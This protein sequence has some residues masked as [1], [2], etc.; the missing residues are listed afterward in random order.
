MKMDVIEMSLAEYFS[1]TPE[2]ILNVNQGNSIKVFWVRVPNAGFCL[3]LLVPPNGYSWGMQFNHPKS[4]NDWMEEKIND[5]AVALEYRRIF[6][7]L[8][9]DPAYVPETI[10]GCSLFGENH[11][12]EVGTNVPDLPRAWFRSIFLPD[13][14]NALENFLLRL[15]IH[16]DQLGIFFLLPQPKMDDVALVNWSESVNHNLET[17]FG[18]DHSPTIVVPADLFSGRKNALDNAINTIPSA[19]AEI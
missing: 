10:A 12:L 15:R 19:E 13:A 4:I 17:L 1:I 11:E 9:I 2:S 14:Q 18:S 16:V 6:D 5:S 7:A 8:A 3:A